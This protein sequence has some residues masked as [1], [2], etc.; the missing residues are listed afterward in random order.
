MFLSPL[1]G[2]ERRKRLTPLPIMMVKR[3][4]KNKF[5]PERLIDEKE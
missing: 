3:D 2:W 1:D 4:Y 5:Y